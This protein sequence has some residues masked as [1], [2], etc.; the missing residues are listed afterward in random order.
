MKVTSVEIQP[1]GSSNVAVLSFR[2]PR[3]INP[4]NVLGIEGLDADEIISKF[5]SAPGNSGKFY[6]MSPGNKVI[7]VRVELNP[8]FSTSQSFSDLRDALSR[9]I[10]ATRTGFVD[11][12]FKNGETVVAVISGL[13]SKFENVIMSQ[14]QEVKITIDCGDKML[15]A[16]SRVDVASLAIVDGAVNF[17]DL[18]STAHHGFTFQAAILNAIPSFEISSGDVW[19]FVVSPV[20][21][22]LVD[23]ILAFSSETGNKYL[24]IIRGSS[25]IYLADVIQT[26]SIWPIQF[27]GDNVFEI[28]NPTDVEFLEASYYPTYWGV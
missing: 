21:G 6:D 28:A 25:V 13:I 24:Y 23:D 12:R 7:G 5:Y 17:E 18:L 14:E 3:R 16:P 10:S 9:M 11:I 22:F 1:Q 8:N 19:S 26:G 2:D 4:Y 20:G 27:Y 15:Q